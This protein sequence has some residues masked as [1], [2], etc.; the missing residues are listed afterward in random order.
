MAG[1]AAQL[2]WRLLPCFD[3]KLLSPIGFWAGQFGPNGS[4]DACV[5]PKD[6]SSNPISSSN[7]LKSCEIRLKF[8][9]T[10]S[11]CEF[12]CILQE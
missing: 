10:N 12:K 5:F 8:D 3:P 7:N 4:S 2:P 1:V 11:F 6:F 9:Q